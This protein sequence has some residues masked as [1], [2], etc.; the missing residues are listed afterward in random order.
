MF[1][2]ELVFLNKII[3]TLQFITIVTQLVLGV[4]DNV[5]CWVL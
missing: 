1:V 5:G 2:V 4:L 3:I